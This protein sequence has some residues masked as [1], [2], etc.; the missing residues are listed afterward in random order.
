ML[1]LTVIIPTTG[2]VRSQA[3]TF[4]DALIFARRRMTS[5][6]RVSIDER[7]LSWHKVRR[8]V[9]ALLVQ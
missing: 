2:A 8:A 7:H 1:L 5:A 4:G 9:L 3:V 6:G